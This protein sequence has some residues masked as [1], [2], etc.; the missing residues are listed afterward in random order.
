D[1]LTF[2]VRPGEIFGFLGP[3][4][5]G[6][7]TTIKMLCTLL[8]PTSGVATVNGYDVVREPDRVR[9][10][11]G[12]IF[13][14]YS[15]DDRITAEENLRFHC[16]I[17]HVP[18]SDR[19]ARIA[20]VLE[21]VD[22]ADRAGDKVR[23]FSGGMKR[24]LEI[25]RGLLHQPAILFLDEPTVGLDPQ[26]RETLW[27]QIHALRRRAG[28]TV[29]MTTHYMDEAEH[30]DRI[31]IIDHAR[32]IALDTP[33]GLK[34]TIGGDVVRLRV[35]DQSAALGFLRERYDLEPVADQDV[36]RFEVEQ[37]DRFV[38]E[39]L[40]TMPVPVISVESAK[41]TLNDVFLHLTGRA[42]R[43]EGAGS[44]DRLRAALRRRGKRGA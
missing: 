4:G 28:M 40:R 35:A 43:D 34:A 15:L 20:Q 5:A 33:E 42:I 37:A 41:P 10:S 14:D 30:C 9:A 39:L 12:I 3:N 36:L 13:Q 23:N 38:P 11:I 32:L 31:G 8:Q 7:S 19:R 26:T 1:D 17:Y 6:K 2:A 29:F 22:L 27:E 21:L 16:M 44:N 25:A 18:R 24:R